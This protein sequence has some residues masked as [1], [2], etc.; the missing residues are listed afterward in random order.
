MLTNRVGY[1]MDK[2][3]S[4]ITVEKMPRNEALPTVLHVTSF[5]YIGTLF[6][7]EAKGQIF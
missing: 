7:P 5:G 3:S 1:E 4:E 6:I 2:L